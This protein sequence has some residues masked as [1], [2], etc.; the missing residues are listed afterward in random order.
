MAATGC[1]Q[2]RQLGP[3]VVGGLSSQRSSGKGTGVT[4]LLSLSPTG[5]RRREHTWPSA[6]ILLPSVLIWLYL[7]LSPV[8]LHPLREQNSSPEYTAPLLGE[9][10]A[11]VACGTSLLSYHSET[12]TAITMP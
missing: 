12:K 2:K 6:E 11:I 4:P 7:N 8:K 3:R 5:Y 1:N 9:G 10:H